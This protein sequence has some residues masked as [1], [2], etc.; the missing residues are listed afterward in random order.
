MFSILPVEVVS[1]GGGVELEM[2]TTPPKRHNSFYLI[3]VREGLRQVCHVVRQ[4]KRAEVCIDIKRAPQEVPP[5]S[6]RVAP[7]RTCWRNVILIP[8]IPCPIERV[9]IGRKKA[10]KANVTLVKRSPKAVS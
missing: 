9:K 10:H 8:G 6:S 1:K 7:N 4:M 2:V 5:P 3:G